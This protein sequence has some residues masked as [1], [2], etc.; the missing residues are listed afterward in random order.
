MIDQTVFVLVITILLPPAIIE[1]TAWPYV[2]AP[3][4]TPKDDINTR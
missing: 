3:K 4:R 1:Q 2:W